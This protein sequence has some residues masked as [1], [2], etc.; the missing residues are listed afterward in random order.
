[1]AERQW[2]VAAPAF[3]RRSLSARVSLSLAGML[4]VLLLLVGF[5]VSYQLRSELFNARKGTILSDAGVRITQMNA[6]LDQST[7]STSDQVQDVVGQMIQ[8]LRE[9]ASGAGAVSVMLLRSPDASDSFVI[10]EYLSPTYADVITDKLRS[11]VNGTSTSNEAFWQSVAIP[12]NSGETEPAIVVGARVEVPL[13]GPHDLFIVYSLASEESTVKLVMQVLAVASVP[14]LAVLALMAFG[15][16]YRMLRPVRSTAYAAGQLASG[17]L[18]S[19]V[20]VS[21]QHEMAQLGS[22]FN[23]MA[24]SLQ[25]QIAQYDELSKLQQQFV[26]DVSHELR[27]PLTTIRMAEEMIYDA[28]DSLGV[29]T[30]RSAELLH[31]QVARLEDMLADLLEMSRYDAQSTQLDWETVDVYS[32]VA[33][34]VQDNQD[35]A[36]HLGV[37][38]VLCERPEKPQAEIDAKRIMRVVRNLLVNA[39]EHAEGKPVEVT[40][41]ASDISVAVSVRDHGVGMTAETME[42][43][44]DRFYRADPARARTTG[45]TGLGLAIAKEDV[46]AH[47]GTLDVDGK[48]GVGAIFVLTIP[49]QA[50]APVFD[51]PLSAEVSSD[52]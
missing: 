14:I 23:D 40:V 30:M 51:T 50:G 32:L 42:R 48:L 44:F 49:K 19:R 7:A 1:M 41:A 11:D 16:I 20:D 43:V 21:G 52:D 38:V 22:A 13:A 2:K 47:N 28:R 18:E 8:S 29:A 15:L 36:D 45:G 26:S 24:D 37:T 39:Y 10:N 46:L 31:S 4:I 6:Q 27:T 33:K 34:A 3:W 25:Q 5:L 9:S 35:L 17:D 12:G